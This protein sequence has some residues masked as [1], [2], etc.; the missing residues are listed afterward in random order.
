MA[1]M[2]SKPT[3]YDS[4][5]NGRIYTV[6]LVDYKEEIILVKAHTVESILTEKTGRNQ[7]K[8]NQ[9]DFPRFSKEVMQEAGK[10]LPNKY[11]DMLIGN[12]HLA[13]QPVY[14]SGFGCQDCAKGRCLDPGLELDMSLLYTSERLTVLPMEI[15]TSL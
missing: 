15:N 8:L 5:N 3:I 14:Q 11:V 12:P 9:N 13:L 1:A 4:S 2:G 7:V 6:P 10:S